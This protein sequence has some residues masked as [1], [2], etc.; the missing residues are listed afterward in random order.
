MVRSRKL[1][2]I[3]EEEKLVENAERVGKY[4]IG[5][6]GELAARYSSLVKN[7]R[8]KGLMCAFDLPSTAH[9]SRLKSLAFDNGALII[10]C[11]T[12]SDSIRLRPVLDTHT[13]DV[14]KLYEIL[15]KVFSQMLQEEKDN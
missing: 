14:D 13:Q 10:S 6:L 5:K 15:D 9:C 7:V 1:L 12:K 2:E 8:G 3:I 4:L 11:G